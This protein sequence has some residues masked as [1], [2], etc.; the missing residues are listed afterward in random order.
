MSIYYSPSAHAF[1]D[2]AI[3]AADTI[4]GDAQRITRARHR[5]LLAAQSDGAAIVADANGRPKINRA[6]VTIATRCA[7]LIRRVK[8]EAARR[9]EAASPIWRQMND[10]R[11]L[12]LTATNTPTDDERG[13]ALAR[14][15]TI[16]AIRAASDSIEAE[17]TAATAAQLDALDIAT[18]PAWPKV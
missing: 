14:F 3:H 2:D 11:W 6:P 17:I 16:D 5:D 7:A 1:Y 9:I 10:L 15:E 4:P 18:H 8:R 13:Q 12:M